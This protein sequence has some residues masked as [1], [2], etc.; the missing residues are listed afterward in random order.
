MESVDYESL[1]NPLDI[2]FIK[3]PYPAYAK[4]RNESPVY[5][6]H[7]GYW[8]LSKYQDV[9]MVLSDKRFGKSFGEVFV[10]KYGESVYEEPIIRLMKQMML[11]QNPPAHKCPRLLAVQAFS[12]NRISAMRPRIQKIVDQILDTLIQKN[13]IDIIS[14]FAHPIPL[15]V[16]CELMGLDTIEREQLLGNV[17]LL[18]TLGKVFNPALLSRQDLDILNQN[19][20]ILINF[21]DKLSQKRRLS[22]TDDLISVFLNV[23]KEGVINHE[24]VIANLILLFLAAYETTAKFIGNAVLVLY[25][26]PAERKKLIDNKSLWPNAVKEL[27][28][29]EST[30]QIAARVAFENV[31]IQGVTIQKGDSILPLI[32]SAN[33]DPEAYPNPD[34]F[35][36]ARP[37]DRILSFGS[38]VHL[39]PGEQ[40]TYLEVEIAISS[41]LD[42]LPNLKIIECDNPPWESKNALRG[43]EYLNAQW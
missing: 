11:T 8:V 17:P 26:F 32:G 3:N 35:N 41:L 6:S 20:L 18:C 22:P 36:I 38:G 34:E 5:R 21:F 39:C 10:E 9:K 19:T 7:Y 1:Y 4:L 14:E 43:L 23:E 37:L 42:R 16:S 28:R 29:Y 2:N 27:M 15:L 13:S 24:T 30:M 12:Q 40:L 31:T 33:R 25:Q